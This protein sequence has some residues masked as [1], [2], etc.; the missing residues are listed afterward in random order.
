MIIRKACYTLKIHGEIIRMADLA[1]AKMPAPAPPRAGPWKFWG[2][3]LWALASGAG[4]F[5]GAVIATFAVLVRLNPDASLPFD[6]LLRSHREIVY[7]AVGAGMVGTFAVIALAVRLS[8]LGMREYLG[9][10]Q[11]RLRDIAVGIVGL[12]LLYIPLAV[13]SHFTGALP[14]TKYMIALYHRAATA[15]YLPALAAALIIVAP[16]SEE[17]LVRGF[18]LRGWAASAIGPTAAIVLTSAVWTVLHVQYD[19]ITLADI[20]GIG[21]L[22]GWIRIRS[23][24]TLTTMTLHA[25]QNASAFAFV[26][27]AY[28]PQ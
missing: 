28:P 15:G 7:A 10:I 1:T 13:A 9:L 26:A 24:S 11:P 8:K 22:L 25:L 16:L 2:T 14:S 17:I 20:F 6:T 4:F 27:I 19:L 3:T 23:G 18:L 5:V 21:L 12:T